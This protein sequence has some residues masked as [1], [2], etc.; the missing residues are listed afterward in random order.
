MLTASV[1]G[2]L[3]DIG[4]RIVADHFEMEGWRSLF[5]GA[6]TPVGDLVQAVEDFEPDLVALSVGLASHVRATAETIAALRERFPDRPIL[7]GGRP[8]ELVPDLWKDVGADGC[9]AD[10]AAAV[11]VGARLVRKA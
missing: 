6:N 10:A 5:L 8:F 1:S 7:V 11:Q 9:A 2:N 4:A 3:H